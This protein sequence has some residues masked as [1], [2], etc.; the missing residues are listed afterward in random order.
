VGGHDEAPTCS[1]PIA[2]TAAAT[3]TTVASAWENKDLRERMEELLSS[4]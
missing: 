4:E 1:A 3:T 2:I